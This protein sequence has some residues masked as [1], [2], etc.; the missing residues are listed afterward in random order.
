MQQNAATRTAQTV[1]QFELQNL[2]RKA[3]LFSKIKLTAS[4]CLVLETLV[5]HYPKIR[6]KIETIQE[7]TGRNPKTIKNALNELKEK[8]L[9]V[10]THTGRSSIF[11]LTQKFF[12]LLE[13]APQRC[14]N[15]PGRSAKIALP[16]NKDNNKK[17]KETFQDEKLKNETDQ[18]TKL[19]DN[20][21][22]LSDELQ[23]EIILNGYHQYNTA[24]KDFKTI[25]Q[26]KEMWD[27]KP[28]NFDILRHFE[29]RKQNDMI[30]R[31][32]LENLEAE[33]KEIF[34]NI[35]KSNPEQYAG[36]VAENATQTEQQQGYLF[37]SLTE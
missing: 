17:I 11:N 23:S 35:Y 24:E 22:W 1:T 34:Q 21:L 14:K 28:A 37:K 10:I 33:T 27:F 9:I 5:Y 15:V 31:K 16:H 12:D 36:R 8:G 26:I 32:K 13:I 19:L 7:E 25:L 4:A 30:F 6:V 29:Q 3:K 20:N 18:I 2:L